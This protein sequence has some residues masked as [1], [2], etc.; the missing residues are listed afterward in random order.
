MKI[1]WKLHLEMKKVFSGIPSIEKKITEK[2]KG[3]SLI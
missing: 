1:E 2:S 3:I